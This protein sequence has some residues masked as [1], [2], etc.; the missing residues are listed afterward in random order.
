M[1]DM[2]KKWRARR[3]G[4]RPLRA[5]G[6]REPLLVY[7][8]EHIVADQG[9]TETEI[10]ILQIRVKDL[11]VQPGLDL[12][13][14]QRSGV[15]EA[16]VDA[17]A[18]VGFIQPGVGGEHLPLGEIGIGRPRVARRTGVRLVRR[19]RRAHD[20]LFET[21]LD[22]GFSAIGGGHGSSGPLRRRHRR[23]TWIRDPRLRIR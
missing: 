6:L 13:G 12:L 15:G 4:R 9:L 7:L 17:S 3:A 23:H 14:P 8:P 5:L 10:R 20:D 2:L 18:A 16:F 1:P 11:A 21:P 19:C 22:D